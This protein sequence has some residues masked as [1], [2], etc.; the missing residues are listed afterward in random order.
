MK[1]LFVINGPNLNRL[2]KREP[3]IY[4]RVSLA[5]IESIYSKFYANRP[6]V[7]LFGTKLPQIRYS[8]YTNFCDLGFNLSADGKRL[9]TGT[10]GRMAT[11]WDTQSGDTVRIFGHKQSVERVCLNHDGSRLLTGSSHS[12]SALWDARN[13]TMLHDFKIDREMVLA[14]A[15]SADE[16]LAATAGYYGPVVL[17]NVETGEKLR[18]FLGQT[19]EQH[20]QPEYD[21]RA[22]N[23]PAVTFRQTMTTVQGACSGAILEDHDWIGQGK[24]QV[25]DDSGNDAQRKAQDLKYERKRS[26][27]Y[28]LTQLVET[29]AITFVDSGGIAGLHHLHQRIDQRRRDQNSTQQV[30]KEDLNC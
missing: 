20:E 19:E 21:R 23:L 15:L 9:A 30:Q 8:L 24:R 2:G 29:P 18:T 11:I 12:T 3:E 1:P 7:R 25:N 13:G 26:A 22:Q 16:K 28:E 4:G 17:W 14:V 6:W 27:N 10:N 5:E